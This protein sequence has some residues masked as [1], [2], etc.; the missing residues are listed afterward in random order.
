MQD[1]YSPVHNDGGHPAVYR[2]LIGPDLSDAMQQNHSPTDW[3]G[4]EGTDNLTPESREAQAKGTR[5]ILERIRNCNSQ[6]EREQQ[7]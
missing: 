5:A 7:C 1:S 6:R 3:Y 2:D 4:G